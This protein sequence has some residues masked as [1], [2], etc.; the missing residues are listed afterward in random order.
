MWKRGIFVAALLMCMFLFMLLH[1]C[2]RSIMLPRKPS[3][4][5][6][7]RFLHIECAGDAW[8]RVMHWTEEKPPVLWKPTTTAS[9][10]GCA[11][12]L[13]N[14]MDAAP[15]N[16]ILLDPGEKGERLRVRLVYRCCLSEWIWQL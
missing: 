12:P 1:K 3:G 8:T 14:R 10:S 2:D 7:R 4:G 11:E 6:G 9:Q 15:V 5:T 16:T 13:V